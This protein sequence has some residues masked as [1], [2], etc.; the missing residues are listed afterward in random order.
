MDAVSGKIVG[1]NHSDAES[2]PKFYGDTRRNGGQ[3]AI[4]S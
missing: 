3:A 4:P 2:S 1:G